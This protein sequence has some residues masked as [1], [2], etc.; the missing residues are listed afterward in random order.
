VS[1]RSR[2]VIL[3]LALVLAVGLVVAVGFAIEA[4]RRRERARIVAR[5]SMSISEILPTADGRSVIVQGR[6]PLD[7]IVIYDIVAGT[8]GRELGGAQEGY[9]EIAHAPRA[10]ALVGGRTGLP[11][12]H[13]GDLV[14]HDLRGLPLPARLI[15]NHLYGCSRGGRSVL[16]QSWSQGR[17]E[18][19]DVASGKLRSTLPFGPHTVAA[20]SLDDLRFV[21]GTATKDV[22]VGDALSGQ[23][24]HAFTSREDLVDVRF[25]DAGLLVLVEKRAVEVR[26]AETGTVVH[27]D[28]WIGPEA[29][30]SDLSPDGRFVAIVDG[31]GLKLRILDARTLSLVVERRLRDEVAELKEKDERLESVAFSPDQDA[32]LIGT[33]HGF[34]VR[35]PVSLPERP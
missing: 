7:P 27:E 5:H 22:L 23:T 18:V 19:W 8:P 26:D 21:A 4:K 15:P 6:D 9:F 12:P 35:V 34:V 32:I 10:L 20:F 11:A 29:S 14:V 28:E 31:E 17:L 2:R 1:G 16:A 13:V 24:V 33:A 30:A 3:A 25:S